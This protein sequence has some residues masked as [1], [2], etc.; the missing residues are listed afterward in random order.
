MWADLQRRVNKKKKEEK[1]E[2]QQR[3]LD[4]AKDMREKR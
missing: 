2:H 3:V 4:L 1:G